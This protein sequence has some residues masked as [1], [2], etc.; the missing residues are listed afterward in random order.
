MFVVLYKVITNTWLAAMHQATTKNATGKWR[1]CFILNEGELFNVASEAKP[2]GVC[3][4][5]INIT[6]TYPKE[7]GNKL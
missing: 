5:G 2:A 6:I 4:T 3:V 7:A 1:F